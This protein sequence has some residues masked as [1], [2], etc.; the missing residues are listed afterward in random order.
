[1]PYRTNT[2]LPPAV[3]RHL[4]PHALD[5]Y[6]EAFNN[7]FG[8]MRMTRVRKRPHT[9]SPGRPSSAPM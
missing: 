7:A 3:Q 4:P 9:A 1:M 6:R 5:T 8:R 2:D